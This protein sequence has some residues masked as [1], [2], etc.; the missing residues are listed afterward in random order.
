MKLSKAIEI[1]EKHNEWRRGNDDYKM[2]NPKELG[3]AI[4]TVVKVCKDII[5]GKK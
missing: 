5:K 2:A 3:I 1:L 4:E